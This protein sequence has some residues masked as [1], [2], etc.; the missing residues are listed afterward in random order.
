[1]IG[2]LGRL[3]AAATVG[4]HC[5]Q[6]TQRRCTVH[7]CKLITDLISFNDST[8]FSSQI[9]TKLHDWAVGQAWGSCYSWAA[10]SSNDLKTLYSDGI[11]VGEHFG[12]DTGIYKELCILL[13]ESNL[14]NHRVGGVRRF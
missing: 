3:G 5:S 9:G 14:R 13:T 4:Q 10:L 8:G 12:K 11:D 2:P 6:M 7:K 1:M